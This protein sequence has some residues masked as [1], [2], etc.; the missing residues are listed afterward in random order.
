M[1]GQELFDQAAALSDLASQFPAPPVTRR[2][3]VLQA[4]GGG[5]QLGAGCPAHKEVFVE[6][7]DLGEV[8]GV[9]ADRDRLAYVGN[10]ADIEVTQALEPDAVGVHEPGT[11]HGEQQ[12]V[13]VLYVFGELGY[14]A[15]GF[16]ARPGCLARLTVLAVMVVID[17]ETVQ[18]GVKL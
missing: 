1:D 4:D 15:V 8:P 18:R 11:G 2:H 9:V 16:P 17:D 14:E 3:Q 6:D 7:P 13:E 12:K 5:G 10:E